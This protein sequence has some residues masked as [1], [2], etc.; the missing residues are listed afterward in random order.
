VGIWG[1]IGKFIFERE[2]GGDGGGGGCESL[3]FLNLFRAGGGEEGRGQRAP[4]WID[5]VKNQER[6]RVLGQEI[7]GNQ[8]SST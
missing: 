4:R 1:V 6:R 3:F 7:M 5:F 2:T 8:T